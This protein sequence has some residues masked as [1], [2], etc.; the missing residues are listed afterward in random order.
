MDPWAFGLAFAVLPG[1]VLLHTL[2][3]E[4]NT[5]YLQHFNISIRYLNTMLL[6]CLRE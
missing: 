5:T 2:L 6:H 1:S 3:D 4:P